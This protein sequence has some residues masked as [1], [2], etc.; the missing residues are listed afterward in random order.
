MRKC[1]VFLVTIFCSLA[2]KVFSQAGLSDSAIY[3]QSIQTSVDTYYKS[4]GENAHLYNG[5]EY[6]PFNYQ[7]TSKN[8]FF[9]TGLFQSSTLRYDG[10]LYNN[11]PLAY[12]IYH[13]EVI[14]N[15]YNQSFRIKL[16]NDKLDSFSFSGYTFIR[17]VRDSSSTVLPMTGF[18][19]KLYGGKVMVLAKRKKKFEDVVTANGANGQFVEDD[20][21][22]IKKNGV[23]YQVHNKKSTLKVLKDRKKEVQKLLR[24]NK[25]KFKPNVEYGITKAAQYYDQIQN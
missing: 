25:I 13:E 22:F 16:V 9:E 23:Y 10:V 1:K 2:G 6:V 20:H 3:R 17:V 24:K 15:K 11:V 4:V 19:Q 18:Y 14:I 8:P 12:D 21:Y 7:G 5:S